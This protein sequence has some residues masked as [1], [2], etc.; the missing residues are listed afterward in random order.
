VLPV[1]LGGVEN[2]KTDIVL[3]GEP[4]L[5]AAVQALVANDF[6]TVDR[7]TH[8]DGTPT[9]PFLRADHDAAD[10]ILIER[11]A[12]GIR[13]KVYARD[14]SDFGTLFARDLAPLQVALATGL[15][16]GEVKRHVTVPVSVHDAAGRFASVSSARAA[17]GV[18]SLFIILLYVA[19]LINAQVIMSSVAEEK[20]S[21]IAELLVATVDP[22]QLLTAK[23]L[24]AG[25]AGFIQL[26]VWLSLGAASSKLV[27]AV[28][29]HATAFAHPST[30]T[31]ISVSPGEVAAFLAF[32]LVGFAQ[33]SVLYAA[34]A[35]L[36]NRTEDLGAVAAPVLMPVLTGFI[37]AEFAVTYPT[38]PWIV[39]CS[40]LPLLAPFV[41]FS[42]IA[43]STVP[44]WQIGL[45]LAINVA[46]AV[47][48][49]LA[50]GRIYRVGL[51]L[52]GRLPTPA[53]VVR[54]L[55]A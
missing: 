20:T 34:A 39:A 30:F 53:Q 18:A 50:A 51:L 33:Y 22:A 16:V 47:G 1:M 4:A 36:I 25:A 35:S 54:A 17:K 6:T 48:F 23:V 5:T 24:A 10:A 40:Q 28:L 13:L 52:Y 32:F 37:V 31:A 43:T 19:I 11:H 41:M 42:R 38:N 7:R 15:H 14:P 3:V 46:A 29:P 27:A 55:R 49:A 12:D 44:A 26:L 45:S 9:V 2:G 21:R 8:I